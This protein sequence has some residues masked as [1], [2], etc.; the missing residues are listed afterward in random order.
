MTVYRLSSSDALCWRH[1][2]DETVVYDERSGD[3]HGLDPLASQIF[4]YL[5]DHPATLDEISRRICATE[6]TISSEYDMMIGLA[7]EKLSTPRQAL[8]S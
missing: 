1:F 5:L 2:D 8:R 3:T 4:E 7:V 6:G